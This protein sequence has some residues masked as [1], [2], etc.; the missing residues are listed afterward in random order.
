MK[1]LPKLLLLLCFLFLI[2][3]GQAQGFKLTD[4]IQ[5][6]PAVATGKLSNGLTYFIR[7]N[8][9][10]FTNM[11]IRLVVNAGS[12]LEDD[13]QQGLAHFM[14]HMNFNGL[15]HFPKNELLTY[16]ESNGLKLGADLNANTGYDA[17]NYILW[18]T[19]EDSKKIDKGFT[20]AEDW[21]NNALLDTEE[22]DMERNVVLEESR[23]HKNVY[24]RMRQNYS[25]ILFNQSK[26]AYR[27][28][29]GKDSIISNFH[30]DVLTRYY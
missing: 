12:L 22:I 2:Y 10:T 21:A 16:L 5:T 6:D 1:S 14:E 28:P 3:S 13:D 20:I 25:P 24:S 4:T 26:Y 8:G 19:T 18:I 15:K 17:T 29:I 30:Y 11:Q 23:L 7:D 9:N 27:S